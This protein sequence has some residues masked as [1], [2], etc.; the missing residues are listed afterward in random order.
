MKT[1]YIL[2]IIVIAIAI[3]V[4]IS[5]ASD[6][7]TYVNFTE[8][9]QIASEAGNKKVHVVGKLVKDSSGN[10]TGISQSEDKLAFSFLLS[11]QQNSQYRVYYDEPM[12]TDFLRSEQVVVIGSFQKDNFVA[13]K[14]LLKCPSK[15]QEKSLTSMN[16]H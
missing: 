12:P 8:A 10:I 4:I 14:I 15:Y 11:D 7:S 5:T 9:K 1:S 13:D 3:G 16:T 2:G 6:A